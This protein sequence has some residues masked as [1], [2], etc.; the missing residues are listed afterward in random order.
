MGLLA[1]IGPSR[2]DHR[3]PPAVWARSL[4]RMRRSSQKRKISRS[5][6]GKSGTSARTDTYSLETEGRKDF[7]AR[8]PILAKTAGCQ[9]LALAQGPMPRDIV[10]STSKD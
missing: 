3:G 6:A 10:I 2:N 5:I 1:V 8:N 4:S 9:R 7:N